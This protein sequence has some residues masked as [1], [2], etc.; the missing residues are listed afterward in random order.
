MHI[1]RKRLSENCYSA[2]SSSQ[3]SR[4]VRDKAVSCCLSLVLS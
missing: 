1:Y 3:K 2:E 4:N